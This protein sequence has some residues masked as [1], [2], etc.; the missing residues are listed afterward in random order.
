MKD[1]REVYPE[2]ADKDYFWGPCD[3]QPMLDS[4]GHDILV[5]VDQKDYQGDSW[6]LLRDSDGRVGYLQFGWGSCS[7]CDA[8]QA[9][10]SYEDLE[11]L[12]ENISSGTQWFASAAQALVWFNTHDWELDWASDDRG[13]FIERAK[14]QLELLSAAGP[15]NDNA[16]RAVSEG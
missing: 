6:L 2:A 5:Q 1:I 4:L 3:Y 13:L 15:A 10:S 16:T 7:G 12:R 8:L 9:S 14:S 11:M